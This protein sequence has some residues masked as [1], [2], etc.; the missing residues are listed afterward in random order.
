VII[1]PDYDRTQQLLA[2]ERSLADA[3]EAHGTLAG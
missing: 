1:P 3:A 2:Q